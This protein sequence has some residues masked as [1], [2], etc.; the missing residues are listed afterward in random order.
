[1]INQ[2]LYSLQKEGI[3]LIVLMHVNYWFV[4]IKYGSVQRAFI[5][6]ILSLL[7]GTRFSGCIV[8]IIE[9]S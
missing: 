3:C 4:V 9:M 1:M 8:H 7:I 5:G 6:K 2:P